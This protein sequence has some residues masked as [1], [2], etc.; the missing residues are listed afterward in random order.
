M[1]FCLGKLENAGRAA[2]FDY[3][4]IGLDLSNQF[5]AKAKFDG[6]FAKAKFDP[7]F[8]RAAFIQILRRLL[9]P[10]ILTPCRLAKA[11]LLAA[12]FSLQAEPKFK[13]V[14]RL[15]RKFELTYFYQLKFA[16]VAES[17]LKAK[18]SKFTPLQAALPSHNIKAARVALKI[19]LIK[20]RAVL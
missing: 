8:S 17:N 13:F 11:I 20:T 9:S 18:R 19:A 7:Q 12:K 16:I 14:A 5:F 6:K 1:R 15:S 10:P 3:E 4:K 2:R